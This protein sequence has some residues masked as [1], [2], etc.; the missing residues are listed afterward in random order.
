MRTSLVSWTAVVWIA[1]ACTGG[2]TAATFP[3]SSVPQFVNALAAALTNREDDVIDVDEGTYTL[4]STLTYR[5]PVEE[6]R[7]L[8]IQC[9]NGRAIIDAGEIVAGTMRGMYITTSGT[10]AHVTLNGLTFQ[11][12]RIDHFDIGAGIYVYLRYGNLSLQNC[13]VRNNTGNELYN[14]V[15]AAGAYLRV[16]NSPGA[17]SIRDCVFSNNFAKGKGGGAY[18][19]PSY[20][21][22]A[23]LINNLF[24]TNGA[25]T[26]G[27]GAYIY[28]LTGTLTLDSNTFTAN[29]TGNGSGGGAHIRVYNDDCTVN[30]RNNIL[31]GNRVDI[32]S[33]GDLHIEDDGGGNSIGATVN[34]S[35]CDINGFD[36][37]VG[38]HLTQ[39]SNTNADPLL[40]GDFHLRAASPCIDTGTNLSWM[41]GATDMD[42][43]PRISN[44]RPDMGIDEV[45]VAGISL[46]VAG[47]A[48]PSVWDTTVDAKCQLRYCTNL[49][50][51]TWQDVGTVATATSQR[52]TLIDTN[53][54]GPVRIYSLK[55]LRP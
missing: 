28:L 26:Q 11:N 16:D 2:L 18:M 10:V 44:G 48:A 8:T 31:W 24:V 47:G 53:T 41:T 23:T 12:G 43:Q 25:G 51:A 38:N 4:S 42:G 9:T 7:S 30:L 34:V 5:A 15:D 29:W 35:Y 45:K 52:I 1:F 37:Q 17:M 39:G 32:G 20:G 40:T 3:V 14:P 54:L 49:V 27:G 13:V 55:W 22:S 36:I 21:G 33:G 6:N 19:L 50:S 46:T